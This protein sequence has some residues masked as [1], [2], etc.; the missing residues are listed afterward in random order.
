MSFLS[1]TLVFGGELL[2]CSVAN[3]LPHFLFEKSPDS[4]L[5][6]A[7][8]HSIAQHKEESAHCLQNVALQSALF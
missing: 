2:G 7:Q 4:L 8:S 3:V 1:R 5:S 6:P